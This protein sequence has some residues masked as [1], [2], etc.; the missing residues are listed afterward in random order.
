LLKYVTERAYVDG[1][2]VEKAWMAGIEAGLPYPHTVNWKIPLH[3]VGEEMEAGSLGCSIPLDSGFTLHTGSA[4]SSS[5]SSSSA[6]GPRASK[7]S[8]E[9]GNI[10][11]EYVYNWCSPSRTA[12][13]RGGVQ[14]GGGSSNEPRE[15]R[16]S[17]PSGAPKGRHVQIKLQQQQQQQHQLQRVKATGGGGGGA[18][19]LAALIERAKDA[20]EKA[21]R[22]GRSHKKGSGVFAF[23]L[24][25][26]ARKLA[27]DVELE[28]KKFHQEKNAPAAA[29]SQKPGAKRKLK[30][31]EIQM[32]NPKKAKGGLAV[33]GEDKQETGAYKEAQN[34]NTGQSRGALAMLSRFLGFGS[35]ASAP[36]SPQNTED[37]YARTYP[38]GASSSLS[39]LRRPT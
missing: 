2:S 37:T 32:P 33:G 18:V 36:R 23:K 3:N 27:R 15:K 13:K 26:V 28:K 6:S 7:S 11:N 10:S 8:Y 25:A 35:G 30:G 31:A 29:T 9:G 19:G 38:K 12:G 1:Y 16:P 22:A 5:S 21:A 34:N 20:A 14:G 4:A 24:K 39:R 17:N